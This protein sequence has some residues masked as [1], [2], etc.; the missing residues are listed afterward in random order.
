MSTSLGQHKLLSLFGPP[1][2]ETGSQSIP[3][4]KQFRSVALYRVVERLVR[5]HQNSIL[6]RSPFRPLLVT[7]LNLRSTKCSLSLRQSTDQWTRRAGHQSEHGTR[8]TRFQCLLG[9]QCRRQRVVQT[10][11][12]NPPGNRS[13]S[14]ELNHRCGYCYQYGLKR[15]SSM[16]RAIP[17]RRRE[18]VKWLQVL[19]RWS[20]S[21]SLRLNS[22]CL[23]RLQLGF[24]QGFLVLDVPVANK[25]SCTVVFWP[26]NRASL[27]HHQDVQLTNSGSPSTSGSMTNPH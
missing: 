20:L 7:G 27:Q 11:R 5:L 9:S 24:H 14:G 26:D 23:S 12:H 15:A 1:R 18:A 8:G 19:A 2:Q 25:R 4:P 22:W 16:A 17:R 10:D 6:L 3:G 21:L 13:R